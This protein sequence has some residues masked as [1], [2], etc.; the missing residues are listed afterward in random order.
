[1]IVLGFAGAL[2]PITNVGWS[3]WLLSLGIAL[4]VSA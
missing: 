1:M 3:R 4:V 2:V